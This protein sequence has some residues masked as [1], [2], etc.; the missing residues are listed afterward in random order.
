MMEL[1][2]CLKVFMLAGIL[3]TFQTTHTC[4]DGILKSRF[5][6]SRI[7]RKAYLCIQDAYIAA[8]SCPDLLFLPFLSCPRRDVISWSSHSSSRDSTN[9]PCLRITYAVMSL[10]LVS[11]M[12]IELLRAILRPSSVMLPPPP[13]LLPLMSCP[14]GVRMPCV[15]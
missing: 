4:C 6:A 11:T 9:F 10:T 14:F 7:R 2:L 1:K 12:L 3:L 13:C 5:Y 8:P 15:R